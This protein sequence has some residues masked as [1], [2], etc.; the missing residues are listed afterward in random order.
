[1]SEDE[2]TY[3]NGNNDP[4]AVDLVEDNEPVPSKE[5]KIEYERIL[6]IPKHTNVLHTKKIADHDKE[7]EEKVLDALRRGK[8]R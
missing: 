4:K 3:I 2:E 1:M 8:L 7:M 5:T 6:A